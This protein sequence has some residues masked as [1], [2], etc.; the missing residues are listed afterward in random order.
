M[1]QILDFK[2]GEEIDINNDQSV[3]YEKLVRWL[4]D[5]K[6][7]LDKSDSF[8]FMRETQK[9][10]K[11]KSSGYPWVSMDIH[12]LS[13]DNPWVSMDYPRIIDGYPWIIHGCPWIIH[14]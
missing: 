12:G 14:G 11:L 2:R 6:G 10:N 7:A 9:I 13:M 4:W 8:G 3:S 5:M 1:A